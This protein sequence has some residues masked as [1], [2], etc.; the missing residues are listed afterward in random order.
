MLQRNNRR[1]F[2]LVELLVVIA[3]I[4]ILIALLLPAVQAAREA[5]R[6]AQ[7]ANNL[8][9]I[10]L[11][12]HNYHDTYRALPAGGNVAFKDTTG[13]S[14]NSLSSSNSW[15]TVILPFLEQMTVY[16]QYDLNVSTWD[17][18]NAEAVANVI[19]GYICPSVAGA[20]RKITYT[21][22]VGTMHTS[23]YGIDIPVVAELHL[24]DAGAIDYIVT[25]G[26]KGDFKSLAQSAGWTCRDRFGWGG[27][28]HTVFDMPWLS[29]Y[30]GHAQRFA[31]IVD[32]MSNTTMI[33]ELGGRNTLY[34]AGMAVAPADPEAIYRTSTG[35][36]AWA[37]FLN[38]ENWIVGRLYDGTD[39][40]DGGPCAINCS[41]AKGNMYSFHPG[42]VQALFGDGSVRFINETI[43]SVPLASM[44]TY[45]N[46]DAF[47]F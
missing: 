1:G 23:L 27:Y 35:G 3:I 10:G 25:S 41:N 16:R 18:L 12:F 7:C 29:N 2:T 20:D 38:G 36:G 22:P 5:A 13:L 30:E 14:V 9:Q 19:A 34:R 32:G 40:G 39:G 15:S 37:D 21:I 42:G 44:I 46:H 6:R 47:S 11:A 28:S 4:G 17:P 45:R 8:K 33:V 24:V 43:G 31:N 26:V